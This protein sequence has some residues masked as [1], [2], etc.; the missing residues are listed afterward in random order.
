MY[1]VNSSLRSHFFVPVEIINCLFCAFQPQ[2][3]LYRH[4][5]IALKSPF[6]EKM[7]DEHIQILQNSNHPTRSPH[8]NHRGSCCS[9]FNCLLISIQFNIS[10]LRLI[11]DLSSTSDISSCSMFRSSSKITDKA[12]TFYQYSIMALPRNNVYII[13]L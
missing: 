2:S 3:S 11:V 8:H 13:Q 12:Y 5:L 9:K 10:V 4:H 1:S 6:G 7:F